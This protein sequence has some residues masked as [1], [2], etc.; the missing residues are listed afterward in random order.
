M[1]KLATAA[2]SLNSH[3]LTEL[4]G[5]G[6]LPAWEIPSW[7]MPLP[8]N[9]QNQTARQ[10]T[11]PKTRPVPQV[12]SIEIQAA[13]S[14][15]TTTPATTTPAT[16]TPATTTP[17]TLSTDGEPELRDP[18]RFGIALSVINVGLYSVM[19]LAQWMGWGG[20]YAA[21]GT[22]GRLL[23]DAFAVMAI[24]FTFGL[25]VIVGVFVLKPMHF[26]ARVRYPLIALVALVAA[27]PRVLA[28]MAIYTTPSGSTFLLAEW[29]SGWVAGTIAVTTGVLTAG[30]VGR[31]R[32]EHARWTNEHE[33][34]RQASDELHTEEMRVRRMVADQ[35]HGRL[36]Y[37]LV[38]IAAG[39]DAD[40][41][42]FGS[43]GS[44][45][46]AEVLSAYA[47][48][49]DQVREQEVRALSHAVYPA[50]IELGAVTAIKAM[51]HRLPPQI[52][53]SLTTG[54]NLTKAIE[55]GTTVMPLAER[56]IA[57][58]TIEEAIT[59]ALKHGHAT[60]LAIDLEFR[61]LDDAGA[62]VLEGKVDDDGR[63]LPAGAK[64]ADDDS[65]H[66][67]LGRHGER[68]TSRGG[69]LTLSNR[70]GGGTRLE[71]SLPFTSHLTLAELDQLSA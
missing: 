62:M 48:Q 71:F 1:E 17:I 49:L 7:Q 42:K 63:G 69:H 56:L 55:A 59:N 10:Y 46:V 47:N 61:A 5:G 54:P 70:L 3:A 29:M 22:P 18:T 25:L 45:E 50:G 9:A 52:A 57:V 68:L 34:A 6:A 60:S 37:R 16:T 26:R 38:T 39:L 36:Q 51:V 35:L 4:D 2:S 15:A 27:A 64:A 13:P 40:A 33:K 32:R 53:A 66:T 8:D 12:S 58:F 41:V 44:A 28:M 65:A 21:S 19:A 30:L 24:N 11:K 23:S 67:G 14:S 43:A 31:A 20:F